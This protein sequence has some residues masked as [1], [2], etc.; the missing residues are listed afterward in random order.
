MRHYAKPKQT[1]QEEVDKYL[2][3]RFNITSFLFDKQLEFIEDES[4]FKVAVC[5]RRA[6]KCRPA[7]TLVKTP[8]GARTIESLRPGD[9][10]YGYNADGTVTPTKVT[11]VWD[12]GV[13]DVVDLVWSGKVLAS[14]TVD[15][16][17]LAHNTY[18][19]TRTVKPLKDFNSRDKI[20]TEYVAA[21]GGDFVNKTA[22]ALGAFLGD[23]CSRDPGL[24]IS[25]TDT[26]ILDHISEVL[27]VGW[28]HSG[29]DNYTNFFPGAK[30]SAI[31]MY[32]AWVSNKYAHEKLAEIGE[33]RKWTR[34]SQ[35]DFLAGIID[36]DG[37]VGLQDG[38]L[39]IRLGM[40]AKAVV[41]TVD[42]LL[43][44]LFQVQTLRGVD[45]RLKYKNGPVHT[46]TVGS[47]LECRR[48]LREL[49]TKH[50]TKQ[51]RA[52]Y[53][54]LENRNRVENYVGFD[55]ANL[56][57]EQC[58]DITIDNDT[59]LFLDANGMV[60]HNTISCAADLVSTALNNPNTVQ[61]Y[62][63]LSR[64][65]A[66]KIIWRDLKKICED[67][68]LGATYDEVELSV[69][70]SNKSIIY[71]S[72]AKDA[73]EIEKF[74]GL[75]LKKVYIDEC[76]SFRS[77]IKELIDDII[78]PALMDHAGTLCLIGTPGTVPAGYFYDCATTHDLWAKFH[79][80]FW[81]NPHVPKPGA[82]KTKDQ[83]FEDELKRR[84]IDRNHPSVQREW[85]GKWEQDSDSLILRYNPTVNDFDE[86]PPLP[87]G[88]RYHHIL[89]IDLGYKD[90]DALA[91]LAY[92]DFDA[93][94][95]LVDEV[96]VAKQGITELVEQIKVIQERY[97]IVKMVMDTG[98]LGLK[99][100]EELIKRHQLPIEAAD[101][102]RKIE[103]LSLLDDALRTGR[104][105]AKKDSR[106]AQDS[107]LIERDNDKSRPDRIVISDRFHSDIVDSVLYAFK[108]SPAYSYEP[109]PEPPRFGSKEWADAQTNQMFDDAL[110]HFQSA[111]ENDIWNKRD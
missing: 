6:G 45:N 27:G 22:Y 97:D 102:R 74:R 63:T 81:D 80:T 12:Q 79:W 56:R 25:S 77:Y 11:A 40:Q 59:H 5:S 111:Q 78:A 103:N 71:L 9:L 101:K 66:K 68:K 39:V 109:P 2:H 37:S 38:R 48:I 15:H 98:G 49:P 10:V 24:R 42:A 14:S 13:K 76:Q 88:H 92:S 21:P 72:G 73:S 96:V 105:K 94:T 41:D 7:G 58:Y 110:E 28:Q 20:A 50:A 65:S 85:F 83:I 69:S 53:D 23:G 99:I 61:L 84:G 47:N 33:L 90:A 70:F 87:Q 57:K 51:W 36:T 107:Y 43:L 44:D 67:H 95:Y 1:S 16:K 82:K 35:L 108:C 89:G 32:D 18:K 93:S 54:S 60:G 91:V 34:E 46:L 31:H 100:G 52:E 104:F 75:A 64:V 62:I 26:A 8:Q 4:T 19:N 106:F 17:W 29:H 55:I 30:K 86:L 3:R